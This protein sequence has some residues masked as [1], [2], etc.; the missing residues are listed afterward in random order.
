MNFRI[1]FSISVNNDIRILVGIALNTH[2]TSSSNF[3]SIISTAPWAWWV[4][5]SVDV[6][7]NFFPQSFIVLIMQVFLFIVKFISRYF[8]MLLLSWFISQ[9]V[10]CGY[11]EKLLNFVC[12]S[13]YPAKLFKVFIWSRWVFLV[14]SLGYFF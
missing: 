9:P 14:S 6:F 7:F 1:D 8:W 3:H 11:I 4:S 2:I 12:W 10:H 5:P 13:F